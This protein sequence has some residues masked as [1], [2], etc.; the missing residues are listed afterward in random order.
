MAGCYICSCKSKAGQSR[1]SSFFE[2][3]R[4][5]AVVEN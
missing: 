2:L 4:D 5:D 3:R 1:I